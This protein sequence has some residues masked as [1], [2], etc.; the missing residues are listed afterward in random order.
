MAKKRKGTDYKAAHERICIAFCKGMLTRYGVR[1]MVK[2]EIEVEKQGGI[3]W[4]KGPVVD[5]VVEA[6]NKKGEVV[7]KRTIK[8]RKPGKLKRHPSTRGKQVVEVAEGVVPEEMLKL[9]EGMAAA[10]VE[11]LK[12]AEESGVVVEKSVIEAGLD[13]LTGGGS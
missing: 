10:F 6:K 8:R 12:I 9:A 13:N 5:V 11:V 3:Y 7:G 1:K 4:E 2:Q